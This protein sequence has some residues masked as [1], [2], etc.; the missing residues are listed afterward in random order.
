MH[1]AIGYSVSKI[2]KKFW[3]TEKGTQDENHVEPDTVPIVSTTPTSTSTA[4]FY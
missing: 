2:N 1:H 4:T 3:K